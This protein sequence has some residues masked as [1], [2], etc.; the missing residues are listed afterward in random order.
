ML[1]Q[2]ATNTT[3]VSLSTYCRYCFCWGWLGLAGVAGLFHSR[4]CRTFAFAFTFQPTPRLSHLPFRFVS[5][6]SFLCRTTRALSLRCCHVISTCSLRCSF[7]AH[8]SRIPFCGA[9]VT[10]TGAHT[11][12]H[13]GI[14]MYV[15]MHKHT[16]EKMLLHKRVATFSASAAAECAISYKIIYRSQHKMMILFYHKFVCFSAPLCE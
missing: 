14:H 15:C 13:I 5:F 9:Y 11:H 6:L 10:R 8:F 3:N 2:G 4:G 1:V 16:A 12:A 7:N